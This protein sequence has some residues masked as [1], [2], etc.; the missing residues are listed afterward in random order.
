MSNL[1]SFDNIFANL[2]ESAYSGR[3]NAFSIYQN[4]KEKVEFDYSL[5]TFDEDGNLIKGGKNLP[6]NGKVYL[7]P[8]NT[9]KTVEEK[10]LFGRTNKYQKGLLTD[11]KAADICLEILDDILKEL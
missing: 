9:V 5:D 8:D 2:A 4:S 6:N 1:E 10:K 3:P 7:Q 11:E